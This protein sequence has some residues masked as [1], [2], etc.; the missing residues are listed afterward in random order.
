MNVTKKVRIL[1]IDDEEEICIL[2]SYALSKLGYQTE[3]SQTLQEG[4]KKLRAL[5]PDVVLLDIHLPD[6]SGFSIIPEIHAVGCSFVVISAYDDGRDSAL[7]RG[8][9]GFIKK[10]FDM[11]MVTSSIANITKGNI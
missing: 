10:P 9:A 7:Q 3:Y 8:A 5:Q 1:I 11:E 6:G 2:L 4:S